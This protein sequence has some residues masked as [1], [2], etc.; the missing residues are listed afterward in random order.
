MEKIPLPQL[1][2]VDFCIK[3][4]DDKVRACLVGWFLRCVSPAW[5][6]WDILRSR[7]EEEILKFWS[8][9]PIAEDGVAR[10]PDGNACFNSLID[11]D[12]EGALQPKVLARIW[13]TCIEGITVP[14]VVNPWVDISQRPSMKAK[15]KKR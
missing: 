6:E 12:K 1:E 8:P 5:D 11:C 4:N 14:N 15:E 10:Y 3:I 9:P 2:G 7:L 13:N